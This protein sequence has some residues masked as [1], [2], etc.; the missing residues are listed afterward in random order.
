MPSAPSV[1][2]AQRRVF[3]HGVGALTIEGLAVS[4]EVSRDTQSNGASEVC[5]FLSYTGMQLGISLFML[6][7]AMASLT[8]AIMKQRAEAA[9]RPRYIHHEP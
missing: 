6:E 8:L 2:E 4:L 7:S 5:E 3:S 1:S 9:Y